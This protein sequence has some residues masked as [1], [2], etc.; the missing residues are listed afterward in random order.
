M[1]I[2]ATKIFPTIQILIC[3]GSCLVY[4]Y[5]GDWR[6]TMYWLA[7]GVLTITVTY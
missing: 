5:A 3:F 2:D 4:L 1:K 7:A 6:K